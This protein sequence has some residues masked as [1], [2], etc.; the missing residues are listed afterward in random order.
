MIPTTTLRDWILALYE[1]AGKLTPEIV[2]EAARPEDSL[3]HGFVFNVPADEAAD[4]YYLDRAH[5]L[6]QMVKVEIQPSPD[7]PPRQVRLFHAVT[8]E[9]QAVVYEPIEVLLRDP[10]KLAE[11][12]AAALHRLREAE[13]SVENLELLTPHSTGPRKARKA[14]QQAQEALAAG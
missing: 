2:R 8:G 7:R 5:R 9:D 1:S 3:A 13:T 10:D 6:I 11:A 4:G 14:L 12:R